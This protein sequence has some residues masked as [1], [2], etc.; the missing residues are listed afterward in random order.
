MNFANL[1][2]TTVAVC[3]AVAI[4]SCGNSINPNPKEGEVVTVDVEDATF[5]LVY[6]APGS[7]TMGA[8]PEN[9]GIDTFT[10]LPTHRVT[11]SKGFFIGTTEVTQ[12]QWETVM[13]NNPSQV[14]TF[15]DKEDKTLPVTD[16]T[17][18]EANR[19]VKKLSEMTGYKFRLPTEA[20]WEYAARGGTETPYFFSGN[21]K[22]FS[23]QGF[24][25]KFF[26]AKTDSISSYVIYSKNSQNKTQEPNLVKANPFGLKNMM[27]NVMEY[28]ADKYDPEA[29]KKQ[30]DN[31]VNPLSTEG[32][33]WVV[34]GGNYTSDAADLR[35]AARDYT[36]HDLWLKTDPQQPKS[37]WWYSDIRGIGFRVVCENVPNQ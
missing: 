12:E 32:E 13:G 2:L 20:E 8:T 19:F 1:A 22:D 30:G 31:A 21:P 36:K 18:A 23:D 4:T 7:F 28:C 10:E 16:I 17:W 9:E 3:S 5:E 15:A 33:E 27:G 34:R 14:K 24:W 11:L 25:R 26:D 35:C 29:Y 6:V 37:I